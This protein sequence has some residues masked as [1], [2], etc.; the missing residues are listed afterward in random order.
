MVRER[1]EEREREVHV[2]SN[3]SVCHL[4]IVFIFVALGDEIEDKVF[5]LI[6]EW[7]PLVAQQPPTVDNRFDLYSEPV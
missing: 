1:E 2:Y 5:S 6:K 3:S 7:L 4:E